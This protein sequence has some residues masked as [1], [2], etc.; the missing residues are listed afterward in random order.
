MHDKLW[1][2]VFIKYLRTSYAKYNIVLTE[3]LNSRL[4]AFLI[5]VIKKNKG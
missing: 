3:I 2:K 4:A 5:T 1:K